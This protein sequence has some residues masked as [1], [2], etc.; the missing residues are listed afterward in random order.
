MEGITRILQRFVTT[1]ILISLFVLIFN[2]VLLGTLVFTET[3]QK[4]PSEV[5]LKKLSQNLD[6]QD[7]NYQLNESTIK[8]LQH[9][10]AWAMFIDEDGHVRWDYH[11]PKDV[12]RFYNLV[13]VAKFSRYY[14]L[15]YPVYTWEHDNGLIVVGYPKESHWKYQF[16]FLSDWLREMPLRIG[17]LLLINI[18]IT[19]LISVVI[20]TRFIK[21][22]RPLVSGVHNLAREESVQLDSK[23]ILGDLAQ[24]IN[25]ASTTLKKKTDALK[26]RDEARSNWIAGIS[27]DIRTPLSII[28]GYASEMEDCFEL[29]EEHRQQA[30]II[31]QQGEKL[32]SLISDLN[33]VSMLE[34]E[35]QPLHLKQIRLSVLARQV[36]TD[37]LNNGLDD[38]YE[39]VLKLNFEAV[40]VMGDEKLLLRAIT[41]LV[42]NSVTHNNQ[43]CI[44]TLETSL[45]KDQS[46][47]RLIVKDNG[48]GIPMEKLTE[49]TEL[50]YS[51]RR[52]RTVQEGHGLGIPM[53]A[54]IV[55][56]HRGN[57]N[58]ASSEDQSGLIATIELPVHCEITV[59]IKGT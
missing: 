7:N 29:P 9:N 40:Q 41:N 51:S 35:M 34:Y 24:S 46:Q 44:I 38:R 23:G 28:L 5:L 53:V 15:Q 47:Y 52:K 6:K 36:A 39:F 42:Q 43:G 26:A 48:Q 59:P 16:S 20:G 19:L 49:I 17:L 57:L 21:G 11:L 32:R 22:I 14:L 1:T 45:S 2:F 3:N 33:L 30:G 58:L 56:A 55:Q 27:H 50:P 4:M 12:P 31:R 54:R 8:I 13:D 10:L 25:S 18:G 37:F